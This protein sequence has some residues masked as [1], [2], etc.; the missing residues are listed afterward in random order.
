MAAR[1]RSPQNTLPRPT[2]LN[3]LVVARDQPEVYRTLQRR[4]RHCAVVTILFDRR[5][6]ERR[7]TAKPVP[8]DR[9]LGERRSPLGR[10][11]DLRQRKY[12]FARPE[13]RCPHD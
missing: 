1:T 12:I 11:N 8:V 9:R 7:Q 3:L 2:V 10:R 4:L 5:Q 6:G 13:A